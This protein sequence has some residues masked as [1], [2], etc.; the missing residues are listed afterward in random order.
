MSVHW[1][2]N[3]KI[4]ARKTIIKINVFLENKL[5]LLIFRIPCRYILRVVSIIGRL[6]S[7]QFYLALYFIKSIAKITNKRHMVT[8]RNIKEIVYYYSTSIVNIW[9]I[10]V[11]CLNDYS[12]LLIG[13]SN[14][15]LAIEKIK[16]MME[17]CIW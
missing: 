2:Y 11:N 4:S 16:M 15:N 3:D 7:F 12:F 10:T 6:L 8:Y 5:Q 1:E 13:F 9:T 14:N 17:D